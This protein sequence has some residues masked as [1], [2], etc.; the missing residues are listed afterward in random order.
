MATERTNWKTSG[1]GGGFTHQVELVVE[2]MEVVTI[3][4]ET[5]ML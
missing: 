1:N 2:I 3:M 5:P 4:H